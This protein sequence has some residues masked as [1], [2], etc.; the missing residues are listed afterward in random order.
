MNKGVSTGSELRSTERSVARRVRG[1]TRAAPGLESEEKVFA[2]PGAVG[3]TIDIPA[4]PTEGWGWW[5]EPDGKDGLGWAAVS[6][7]MRAEAGRG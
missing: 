6:T 1:M 3:V 4:L 5:N 2:D 7:C